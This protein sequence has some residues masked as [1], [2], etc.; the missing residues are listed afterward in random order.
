MEVNDLLALAYYLII[1]NRVNHAKDVYSL[2][3]LKVEEA[4]N[5]D[6]NYVQDSFLYDYLR[7]YMS[8]FDLDFDF[9]DAG[10]DNQLGEEE[11]KNDLVEYFQSQQLSFA[12]T[13]SLFDQIVQKHNGK[14]LIPDKQKL[15]QDLVTVLSDLNWQFKKFML[16]MPEQ[17]QI[18]TFS[19]QK[20]IDD[21][22]PGDDVHGDELR[23]KQNGM[24]TDTEIATATLNFDIDNKDK[25]INVEYSNMNQFTINFYKINVE[26]LFSKHP[27]ALVDDNKS[28]YGIESKQLEFSYVEP[29][30][31]TKIDVKYN[32]TINE[33]SYLIPRTQLKNENLLIQVVN[34]DNSLMKSKSF[35]DRQLTV[36]IESNDGMLR[37][38]TKHKKSGTFLNI[39]KAYVK[40]YFK[41]KNKQMD[42]TF[43]K[44]GYTDF[45]GKFDYVSVSSTHSELDQIAQFAVFVS[46][47]RYGSVVVKAD[48][49]TS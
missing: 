32:S 8:L 44:D 48:K 28:G 20:M 22:E 35:Y 25:S 2:I 1:Q 21:F 29:I 49:P 11:E 43:Y 12:A 34:S 10:D 26:L 19:K 40:V 15:L 45:N 39:P 24:Q 18:S 36:H 3:Q 47:P 41:S 17:Y 42:A 13:I 37:V 38:F 23:N 14:P 7:C 33:Y 4:N 31:S 16:L 27:F 30:V 9:W 6:V 46:H 5:P